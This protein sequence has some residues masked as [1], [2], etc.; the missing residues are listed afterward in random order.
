MR[1]DGPRRAIPY[2]NSGFVLSRAVK[3]Y[4]SPPG[5]VRKPMLLLKS[6]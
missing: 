2:M 1:L 3:V 4:F 5:I 6:L